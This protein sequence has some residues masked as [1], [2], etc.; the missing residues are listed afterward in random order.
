ML[1]QGNRRGIHQFQSGN[2]RYSPSYRRMRVCNSVGVKLSMSALTFS[3]LSLIR[4]SPRTLCPVTL[5]IGAAQ[6][7]APRDF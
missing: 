3:V 6:Q 7:H 4:G 1:S 2:H 5:N